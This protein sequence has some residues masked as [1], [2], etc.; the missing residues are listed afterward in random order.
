MS[1]SRE[2]WCVRHRDGWCATKGGKRY[3]VSAA[4]VPTRCGMFVTGPGGMERRTPDCQ[5]HAPESGCPLKKEL[6][7]E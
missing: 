5:T 2:V 3:A 1:E 6:C 7:H 4:S